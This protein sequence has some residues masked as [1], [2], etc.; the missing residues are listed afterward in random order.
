MSEVFWILSFVA[1]AC[2]WI[3]YLRGPHDLGRL[4][5]LGDAWTPS[6]ETAGRFWM[7]LTL[8]ALGYDAAFPIPAVAVLLLGAALVIWGLASGWA[9]VRTHR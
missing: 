7:G 4:F 5:R 1:F 2:M 9:I 3:L 8:M 6:T